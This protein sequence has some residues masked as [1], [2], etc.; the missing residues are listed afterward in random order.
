MAVRVATSSG[1]GPSKQRVRRQDTALENSSVCMRPACV[2]S[3]AY[4]YEHIAL[5]LL[6]SHYEAHSRYYVPGL[7]STDTGGRILRGH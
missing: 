2:E 7:C 1:R 6:L 5:L 3:R 4:H